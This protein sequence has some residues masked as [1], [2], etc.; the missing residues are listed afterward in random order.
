MQGG[1]RGYGLSYRQR[2]MQVINMKMDQVKGTCLSKYLLK[3][4]N[5]LRELIH[6][7]VVQAQRARTGRHQTRLGD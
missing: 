2:K 6:T 5:V 3:Q 1:H 7:L 4:H